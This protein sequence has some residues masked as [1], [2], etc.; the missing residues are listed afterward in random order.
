[1]VWQMMQKMEDYMTDLTHDMT[2]MMPAEVYSAV[3]PA[4]WYSRSRVCD[5][6]GARRIPATHPTGRIGREC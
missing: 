6:A 3:S 5:D 4:R 2:D 1:M